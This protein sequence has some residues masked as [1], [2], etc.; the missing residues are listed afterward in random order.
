MTLSLAIPVGMGQAA[1]SA[2]SAAV[3]AVNGLGSCI[4]LALFDPG[5]K[6]GGLCHIVLPES[7]GKA[8]PADPAKYADTA[9][10][11]ALAEMARLGANPRRIVAKLAGGAHLF[12]AAFI[13]LLKIGERNIAAV[14][15][16][17][18]ARG[19]TVAARDV[20]GESGRSVAFWLRDGRLEVRTLQGGAKII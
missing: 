4:A 12:Q 16:I 9:V 18:A 20:G 14:T 3:F 8:S 19:I 11:W 5:A 6:V 13:P 15:A 2:D 10:P 7:D 1:F 17:L